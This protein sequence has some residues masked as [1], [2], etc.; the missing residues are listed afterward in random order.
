VALAGA[1]APARAQPPSPVV[2]AP[3]A[4]DWPA[5]PLWP[6]LQELAR[7]SGQRVLVPGGSATLA[8][9]NHGALGGEYTLEEAL[10]A[11]LRDGGHGWRRDAQGSILIV[12]RRRAQ[13][14]LDTLHIQAEAEA[15][16]SAT[17][18]AAGVP[19]DTRFERSGPVRIDGARLTTLPAESV[20]ELLRRAPNVSGQGDGLSIRGIER[21]AAGVATSNVYL[22]GIPL[23]TRL[24]ESAALPPLQR[25]HYLRGPRSLWEGPGAMAGIIRL[26]TEDPGY[27]FGGDLRAALSSGEQADLRASLT[28]QLGRRGPALRLNAL[29]QR[30]G[31]SIDNAATGAEDI[32]R[33]RQHLQQGRLLWEPDGVEPLTLRASFLHLDA[34][35]GS[36]GIVPETPG[37]PDFDPFARRSFEELP[38][39]R[40][41]SAAGG[42]LEIDW[43]FGEVG[44]LRAYGVGAR[45]EL[46][47]LTRRPGAGARERQ[48]RDEREESSEAGLRWEQRLAANWR[49]QLGVDSSERDVQSADA[50]VTPVRDFFP[51][52]ADITVAPDATRRLVVSSLGDI[53]TDGAFAQLE[54]VG[55][56]GAIAGGLR[57]IREQRSADRRLESRLSEACSIRIGTR[58]VDCAAEFPDSVAERS[59]PS[60]DDVWVPNLRANYE[61]DANHRF[62]AEFRRGFVGGGAR[63]DGN[64][65]LAPFRP[66]RSDT[67]DLT[68]S[69]Q[70][71]DGTWQFDAALF[72]NR[73]IDRHV[74]VDLAQRETY[75]IVNAG[76]AHAYGGEFEL[77]WRPDEALQAWIGLGLLHTR[78]DEFSTRLPSGN[79]D[80]SG[81]RFP[82]APP[83]TVAAGL[84]WAFAPGWQFGASHW[85]SRGA[86]SDALNTPEGWR[87]GYGV[88]DL[89]LRREL[90]ANAVLEVF[91]RNALGKD[92]L[93]DVR[94]AG[95]QLQAR[96]FFVGAE[97]RVGVALDFGF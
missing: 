73:W 18:P 12:P 20:D 68:W 37:D 59:I 67:L 21:G 88:L 93:E 1:A 82:G 86:Y 65:A 29:E 16:D 43:R 38:R 42:A 25:V 45:T 54:W 36:N 63:L 76:Q 48:T 55:T 10:D 11:L 3:L 22:D 69:G 51:A 89:N 15:A 47:S 9:E 60:R 4:L 58:I 24:L 97:R 44:M 39:T 52:S 33:T 71:L 90:G 30:T 96:E 57:R 77:Q 92:Y 35:P 85:H 80:L 75:I 81:K 87:P 2:P 41:L 84:R 53:R 83:L 40:D 62:G 50:L 28:G 6:A 5:G 61:P 91:A 74:P 66:E 56:R 72:Y 70:W 14:D 32:D 34:D 19:A 78:Y 7:L 79:A 64:G 49:M 23:G 46:A 17:T 94:I 27:E 13:A 8:G 95:T 26:E 31:G